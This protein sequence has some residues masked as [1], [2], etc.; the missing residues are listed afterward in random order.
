MV[1]VMATTATA[2]KGCE[3]DAVLQ[4][5]RVQYYRAPTSPTYVEQ[6]THTHIET[7]R[8]YAA[9][10]STASHVRAGRSDGIVVVVG[11][12]LTTTAVVA[13]TNIRCSEPAMPYKA[14]TAVSTIPSQSHLCWLLA[15]AASAVAAAFVAQFRCL[16]KTTARML[17]SRPPPPSPSIVVWMLLH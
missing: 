10:M 17:Y 2:S 12:V 13:T 15:T 1:I 3:P 7:T 14:I 4:A 11:F 5:T 9:I 6:H 16:A 8:R